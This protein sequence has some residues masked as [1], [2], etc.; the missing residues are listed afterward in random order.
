MRARM[1][2]VIKARLENL[3]GWL[4]LAGFIILPVLL[5]MAVRLQ[6]EISL[7]KQVAL[8]EAR[9]SLSAALADPPADGLGSFGGKPDG[10]VG[11][12]YGNFWI[13]SY[14]NTVVAAGKSYPCLLAT[15][16]WRG[17]WYSQGRLA[18]TTNGEF[19]W[20]DFRRAP[21]VIPRD[22]RVSKWRT[23]Y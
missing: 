10:H 23:G 16:E 14:T 4:A 11:R 7:W 13:Y 9:A 19:I 3:W 15:D 1:P 18:I 21:K 6:Y 2:S 22:Y 8:N 17:E 12:L 20:L 5:F